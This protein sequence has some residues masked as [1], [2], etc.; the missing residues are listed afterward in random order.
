MRI[1]FQPFT[2][3]LIDQSTRKRWLCLLTAICS[4]LL[5]GCATNSGTGASAMNTPYDWRTSNDPIGALLSRQ[6]SSTTKSYKDIRIDHPLAAQAMSHLGISYRYGGKSPDTGFDCSGLVL[7]SAQQSLGLKLPPR[8]DEQA[9]LGSYV[10]RQD[11]KVG[12]LV[13]F[14]TMGRRY[15]HVGVYIGDDLFVH[16]PAKGGVVRVESMTMRYW[17][18]RYTGARRLDLAE[19]SK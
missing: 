3:A 18:K 14:N 15:S 4:I 7:Y 5:A 16:S 19:L 1:F 9:L 8:A 13:F 17:D 10:S 12:D 2:S 11:L 6:K